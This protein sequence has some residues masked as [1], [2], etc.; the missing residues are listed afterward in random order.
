MN[1]PHKVWI[2]DKWFMISV[3]YI[4]KKLV[5]VIEPEGSHFFYGMMTMKSSI[6]YYKL[7]LWLH[8][9]IIIVVKNFIM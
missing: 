3:R 8:N 6:K 9:Y 5:R 2:S 1:E 7:S 4:S